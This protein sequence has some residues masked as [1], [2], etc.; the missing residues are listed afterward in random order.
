VNRLF[1]SIHSA[2]L[3]SALGFLPVAAPAQPTS[4]DIPINQ[5]LESIQ[6]KSVLPG[7]CVAIVDGTGVRYARGFGYANIA[8]QLPYTANTV[9]PIASISKTLIAVSLM[10]S[11]EKGYFTLDTDVSTVLPFN[12]RNPR[13]PQLPI[14]IRQLATHTSSITDRDPFYSDSYFK[15]SQTKFNIKDF[16]E[17]YLIPG[18]NTYSAKNFSKERPGK[19]YEYSNL[20]A[21]LA[22][23][24]VETKA[25]TTYANYAQTYILKPLHMNASGW[26]PLETKEV[27]ATLYDEHKKV[28]APYSFPSYPDGGLYT[29]CSDLGKFLTAMIRGYEGKSGI[30]SASSFHEMFS[31]QFP[32]GGQPKNASPGDGFYEGINWQRSQHGELGHTGGD[33]GVTT[34]I[35][36][37]PST[38]M[39]RI[40]LTNMSNPDDDQQGMYKELHNIWTTLARYEQN[41]EASKR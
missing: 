12:V 30:L 25:R 18:G 32:K 41:L 29:S 23:L 5:A 31:A 24:A 40:L 6:A 14:T 16:L 27:V 22:A 8:Q 10:Q 15:G 19:A 21:T 28:I 3:V 4:V 38:G 13:F 33:P 26:S 37:N 1:R 20:G 17:S 2:L 9:Q 34:Q 11:V 35:Y 36:F 7:F 39:G